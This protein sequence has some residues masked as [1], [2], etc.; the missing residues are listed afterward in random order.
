M[1]TRIYTGIRLLSRRANGWHRPNG[2]GGAMGEDVKKGFADRGVR[3]PESGADEAAQAEDAQSGDEGIDNPPDPPAADRRTP[4][5][6]TSPRT[7][8]PEVRG[9]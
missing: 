4:A 3:R 6:A 7:G 1:A 8:D 9:E 2:I 5:T